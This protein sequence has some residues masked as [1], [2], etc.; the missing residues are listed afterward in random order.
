MKILLI[1]VV[2]VLSGC[3]VTDFRLDIVDKLDGTGC[4]IGT[5][6][7]NKDKVQVRCQEQKPEEAWY[8]LL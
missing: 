5:Y 7:S 8:I 1:L 2:L 6:Q 3:A 4:V